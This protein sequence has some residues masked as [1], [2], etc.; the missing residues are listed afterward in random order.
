MSRTALGLAALLATILPLGCAD[1]NKTL[2]GTAL[3]LPTAPPRVAPYQPGANEEQVNGKRLAA[4]IAQ[5]AV[6][7]RRGAT[8]GELAR[9]LVGP[10]G[11]ASELVETLRPA[12]RPGAR[13]WGRVVYPQLSGLTATTLG[14]MVVVKQVT[15]DADGVRRS[16]TR[17]VDVRLRLAG[18]SWTLDTLGSIGGS[19]V[20]RPDELSP[21]AERLVDDPGVDLSDTARWDIYRGQVDDS[22]LTALAAAAARHDLAIGVFASGHPRNVWGTSRQSAHTQGLAADIYEVDGRLVIDQ[23]ATG[24]PAYELTSSFLSGRAV[25]IGSPWVL[26]PGGSTSFADAVHQDHIHLQQSSGG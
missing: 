6:T 7:Y 25:Q 12:I 13:S 26:A 8:A 17:V 3:E 1:G 15:E 5:E 14:A 16:W 2:A 23:R 21:P 20:G 10:G 4:R 22:L 24:S 18:T 19:P 9:S 11:N